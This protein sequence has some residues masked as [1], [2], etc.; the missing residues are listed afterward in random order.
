MSATTVRRK[1]V[2]IYDLYPDMG[3]FTYKIER[4]QGRAVQVAAKSLKQALWLAGHDQWID[5]EADPLIGIVYRWANTEY[6]HSGM[7]WCG[8]KSADID[9][10]PGV[11]H[12]DSHRKIKA[13]VARHRSACGRCEERSLAGRLRRAA[14]AGQE[15]AQ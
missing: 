6:G 3:T 8:V 11:S 10:D 15:V 5:P 12:G 13:A 9:I 2:K 1:P 14:R 4:Y 7:T